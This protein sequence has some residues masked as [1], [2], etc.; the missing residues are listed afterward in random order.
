MEKLGRFFHS[1]GQAQGVGLR[2]G[3]KRITFELFGQ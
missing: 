3:R 1:V 2:N